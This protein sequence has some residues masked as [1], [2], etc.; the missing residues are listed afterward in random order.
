MA[1][2][3]SVFDFHVHSS[4]MVKI[5][6]NLMMQSVICPVIKLMCLKPSV[7]VNLIGNYWTFQKGLLNVGYKDSIYLAGY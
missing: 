6:F 1:N 4:I 3:V 2:F 5:L 7:C